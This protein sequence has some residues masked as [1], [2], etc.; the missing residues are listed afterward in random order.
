LS[1]KL[2]EYTAVT[3]DSS[4]SAG[5]AI[6]LPTAFAT[7]ALLVNSTGPEA[8]GGGPQVRTAVERSLALLEKKGLE[9]ELHFLRTS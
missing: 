5:E 1:G 3:A 8:P 7:I 6:M 2:F 9:W 4:P